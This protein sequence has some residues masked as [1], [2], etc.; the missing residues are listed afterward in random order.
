MKQK[1]LFVVFL[2]ALLIAGFGG[3]SV[4]DKAGAAGVEKIG[5]LYIVHGGF[6][7]YKAQYLWD[8][9]IQMFSYDP[10]HSVYKI[11][12]WNSPF[13]SMVL[14]A[15]NAPK[16][17]PKYSY[18]YD[19]LGGID[20]FPGYT[21][22]QVADLEA[23]LNAAACDGIEFVVDWA[24]WMSGEQIEHYAYP[25]GIYYPPSGTGDNVTY[26]GEG[27]AGGPWAG[28]D[29]DRFNVDGPVERFIAA[30]VSKIIAID[31]TTG[32]VRFF[33][34][35]DVIKMMRKG[36]ADY[37]VS[38]PIEW[39]ND[40]QSLMDAS[41]PTD[42]AGWT[43]TLGAP[44][45]D[46]SVPLAGNPNPVVEDVRLAELH[47]EGIAAGFNS[48]VSNADTGV[49]LLNHATRDYAQTY[50]PKIDDT[51]VINQNIK[52]ELIAMGLDPDNIVGAYMGIKESN[53]YHPTGK[54]EYTREMRGEN[55]GHA[56]LYETDPGQLPGGEWGYLYWDALQYLKDRGVQHIVIGFPQITV[57]S[58]L[59]LVE[60][61]IQI[62]KEIGTKNWLKWGTF[63]YATYP[64]TGHPFTDYW[65][66]WVTTDCEEWTLDYTSGS[67][68]YTLGA[69]IAGQ[70]SGAT[71]KIKSY[72]IDSGSFAG[73][74]AAGSL[75]LMNIVGTFVDGET[76]RDDESPAGAAL[77]DG[78]AYLT[79]ESNC[80]FEMGGCGPL[81]QYPPPRM[82]SLNNA[83][84]FMDPSLAYDVSEYGHLGYDQALGAPDPNAPVQNQYTGTWAMYQPPNDDPRV[85][86]MLAD[87]ILLAADCDETLIELAEFKAV[88]GSRKV[89]LSWTTESETNN[90]GFNIYRAEAADG[91]Y[92]MINDEIIPAEG[93]PTEGASYT[94]VDTGVQNRKTYY[95]KLEDIDANGTAVQNGPEKATPRL[96][97]ALF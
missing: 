2:I 48:A 38:I 37:G 76:V 59:N 47:A 32:G 84:T 1:Q 14:K 86:E 33:K 68:E 75:V 66:N 49:I 27:E 79:S 4:P 72:T 89:T 40:P 78:A 44:T 15:G 70:T 83:L 7:E 30:G 50:D 9:S 77:A 43:T 87:H 54:A 69:D 23:E 29:P 22:Q 93:T 80:C 92:E 5:V 42:P 39:L 20:P 73:G 16:E 51:L 65:G 46:P 55:L 60:V 94:F 34:T 52:T 26:C 11:V 45:V 28:C 61:H 81:R 12:I 31:Q 62:A 13:W 63:D 82:D 19:R 74:D 24:G 67:T 85:A 17:I 21:D 91:P 6:S 8:V 35:Y 95:Y 10:N 71:A 96:I 3:M 97:F 56:W 25:R 36:F 53:P 88:P 18:A 41:Y 57:D 90:V 58:V 64:G